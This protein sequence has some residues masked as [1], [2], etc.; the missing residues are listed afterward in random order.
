MEI[1]YVV[2]VKFVIE[3]EVDMEEKDRGWN[4]E[5]IAGD[6]LRRVRSLTNAQEL[7]LVGRSGRVQPYC[8]FHR[9]MALP[10]FLTEKE[11]TCRFRLE[12]SACRAASV[13]KHVLHGIRSW[14][15]GAVFSTPHTLAPKKV[16]IITGIN[17]F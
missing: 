10:E 9:E 14:S 11:N 6:S 2:G 1:E 5:D 4:L 15:T 17:V 12:F 3:N 13:W 7:D 8:R 16:A